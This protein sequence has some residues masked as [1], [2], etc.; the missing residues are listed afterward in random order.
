MVDRNPL[1]L[2]PSRVK[3][4]LVKRTQPKWVAPM[5][6]TLTDERFSREGW[7]FEP[8]WDA[9]SDQSRGVGALL[10]HGRTGRGSAS[11]I[12]PPGSLTASRCGPQHMPSLGSSV[13]VQA[14]RPR[15]GEH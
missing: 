6:A 3:A 15:A 1:E 11:E 13:G 2:L 12:T 8:K 10:R 5:L 14:F 4:R 9:K 7:L